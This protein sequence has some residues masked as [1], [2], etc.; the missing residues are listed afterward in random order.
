VRSE[1]GRRGD[2]AIG[3]LKAALWLEFRA[4]R[5]DLAGMDFVTVYRAFNPA[6]AELVRSRLEA[7]EFFVNMK[8]ENAALSMDGYAMAVGGILVQVP[9]DQAA[10]AR[11]LL[12]S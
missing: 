8:N 11:K 5:P 12:E 7:N 6:D 1:T 10:S 3:P 2:S 9:E 4:G